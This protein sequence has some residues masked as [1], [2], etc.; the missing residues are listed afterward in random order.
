MTDDVTRGLALLADEAEPAPIDTHAVVALARARTRSR[1]A[2]VASTVVTLAAVGALAVTVSAIKDSPPPGGGDTTPTI[3]ITEPTPTEQTTEQPPTSTLTGGAG[4]DKGQ[5]PVLG[6]EVAQPATPAERKARAKRLQ[7]ELIDAFD[8]ILGQGWNHSRFAFACD[9]YGCWAQGDIVDSAG[10]LRLFVYV[11]GDY[12][13]SSCLGP[14]CDKK[15]MDDGTLVALNTGGGSGAQAS[16]S[17]VRTDG[18]SVSI[19][20]E[21][22]KTRTT[23]PLTDDQWREFGNAVTY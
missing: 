22:A 14:D 3:T 15:I 11:S 6:T 5:G 17:S 8:R 21:W 16:V 1:R 9:T 19:H 2:V 23:P 4:P 18:T 12:S 7:G 10:P 13:L 20:A